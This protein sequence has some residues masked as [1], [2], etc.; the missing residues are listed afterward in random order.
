M[1]PTRSAAH[2]AAGSLYP[3]T[4][5][6]QAP[7]RAYFH[8]QSDALPK[9]TILLMAECAGSDSPDT[10]EIIYFEIPKAIG[11]IDRMRTDVHLYVFEKLPATPALAL[12]QLHIATQSFWCRTIG[13][14]DDRVDWNFAQTGKFRTDK[15]SAQ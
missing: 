10:D 4:S 8:F 3:S 11:Q 7:T 2:G 14:E 1:L 15:A 9:R 12:N 13:W 6:R 5:C